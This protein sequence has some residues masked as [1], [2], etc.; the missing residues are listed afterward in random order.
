M[1][2]GWWI[3]AS[4]TYDL[5]DLVSVGEFAI[6]IGRRK[7]RICSWRD[8]RYGPR[9]GDAR[10]ERHQPTYFP[11]S[12]RRIG[13]VELYSRRALNA[14]YI[15]W[16]IQHPHEMYDTDEEVRRHLGVKF[17]TR[18]RLEDKDNGRSDVR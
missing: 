12:L 7:G 2:I 4:R 1:N 8:R 16:V 17:T 18:P 11:L 9:K 13:N 6:E 3:R 5:D 15:H 10:T 14:W